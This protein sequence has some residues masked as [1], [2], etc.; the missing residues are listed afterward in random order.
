MRSG[1]RCHCSPAAPTPAFKLRRMAD[2]PLAMYLQDIYTLTAN[3][4]GLPAISIPCGFSGKGCRSD[5]I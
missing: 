3:L 2:D 1:G 5:C 4:A